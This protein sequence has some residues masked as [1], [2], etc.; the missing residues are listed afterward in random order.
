MTLHIFVYPFPF[1]TGV[2]AGPGLLTPDWSIRSSSISEIAVPLLYSPSLLDLST[3]RC[4]AILA[5]LL[6]AVTYVAAHGYVTSVTTDGQTESGWLPFS[7]PYMNPV[8]T[9]VVRKIPSDGPV[10]DITS[11]DITCNQGGNVGTSK[12]F[13]VN[14]GSDMTFQ[15]T[16]WPADHKGPV[17]TFMASCNGDCSSFTASTGKWFK[18]DQGGY[19]NGQWASDKLI[20]DGNKWSSTIPAGLASGQYLVRYEIVALHSIGHPQY[21]PGCVQVNVKNGGADQPSSSEL[22]TLPGMY[23]EYEWPNIYTDDLDGFVVAGPKLVSFADSNS[24][25]PSPPSSTS[26]SS[27]T[28]SLYSHGPSPTVTPIYSMSPPANPTSTCRTRKNGSKKRSFSVRHVHRRSFN[29]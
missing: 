27:S 21:Y 12:T 17:T 11:T 19:T 2:P 24:S 10:L 20:A 7:D 14:A 9:R 26:P 18:I 13:D 25:D 28:S 8:P 1:L 16:D 4:I 23:N 29:H 6:S 5:T 22:T 3:M 15:W